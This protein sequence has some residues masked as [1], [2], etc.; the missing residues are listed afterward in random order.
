MYL[1]SC[2]HTAPQ[3]PNS[4]CRRTYVI[5]LEEVK[6]DMKTSSC[7]FSVSVHRL[8]HALFLKV[9][10][11]RVCWPLFGLCRPFMIYKGCQD[12]ADEI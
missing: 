3:V 12:S 2:M 4:T 5:N 6:L 7:E 8:K 10:L 1:T 9:F 11:A